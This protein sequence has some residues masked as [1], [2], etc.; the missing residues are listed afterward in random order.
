MVF[1]LALSLGAIALVANPPT[2][3]RSLYTDLVTFA[4][5]FLILIVVWLAY[6][7]LMAALTLAGHRTLQLNIVLLFF[8]SIEPFLFN[9]LNKP[10]IAGSFFDV[11]SQAYAVDLGVM[12]ALLGLFAWGVGTT[13]SPSIPE[14]ARKRFRREALNRWFAAGILFVSA[15]PVFTQVEVFGEPLRIAV[16]LVAVAIVWTTRVGRVDALSKNEGS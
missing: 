14:A 12:V 1:G 8:V 3:A 15:A 10:S 6:T 13:K 16:W 11:V 9:V 4:F 5:S 7:R 2:D